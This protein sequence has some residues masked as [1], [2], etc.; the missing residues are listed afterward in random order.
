MVLMVLITWL[1]SA[2]DARAFV[3]LSGPAEA[4]LPVDEANP[5]IMFEL[6]MEPPSITHKEDF[7][8]GAYQDLSD[9]DY[10]LNLVKLAM[11]PWN[12]VPNSFVKMDVE[13]A[14]NAALDKTDRV[15]SIVVGKTNLTTAA[16]A[17]PTLE[18]KSIVDCDIAVSERGS[19][20]VYMGFTLMHELGHCLGL[21]HNHSDY[22]AVMG[23]SRSDHSLNLGVDDEAGLVYLYPLSSIGKPKEMAGCGVIGSSDGTSGL[24]AFWFLMPICLGLFRP[25]LARLRRSVKTFPEKFIA[26]A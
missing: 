8:D 14:S 4:R 20:A 9:Q 10:W 19:Q 15:F 21:G 26:R 23:Y 24:R 22:T 16:F 3:L 11:K 13:F 2:A 5:K 17:D 25:A 12:D 1:L 6:S 7:E 18:G